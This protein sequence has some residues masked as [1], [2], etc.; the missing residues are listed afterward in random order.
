MVRSFLITLLIGNHCAWSQTPF[1]SEQTIQTIEISFSASNWDYQLDTAKLGGDNYVKAQWVKINDVTF[2]N[3]GVKYKGNSSYDSSSLKNP[4]HI[5]LDAFTDQNYKGVRDIK[6]SNAYA[7]PSMVREVLAYHIARNYMPAPQ[8]NFAKVYINNQYWGLYTNTESINKTFCNNHF[9]S[10]EG[11]FV[12]CNP[13]L[14]PSPAVKSNL[15]QLVGDSTAYYDY[16]EMKSDYGWQYLKGLCDTLT[17]H[18]AFIDNV[19]NIDRV[20]WM[21]AFNTLLVNLDS[22]NGAF[23]QNYYLY[24]DKTGRFNPL[25]WDLNMSF[26]GFPFLG[27]SNTSL[28]N[29]SIANMQ[30]LPLNIHD[31]DPYW[32]LINAIQL[33]SSYKKMYVAHLRTILNQFFNNGEYV[34]LFNTYQSLID[35]AVLNDNRKKYTYVQFKNSLTNNTSVGSYSVPGIQTL[36]SARVNYLKSTNDF[37]SSTPTIQAVT[38]SVPQLNSLINVTAHIQNA[39]VAILLYRDKITNSFERVTM[40]DDGLHDDGDAN[41]Q[42]YGTNFTLK[43]NNVQYYIYSE[44]TNAGIFSPEAAQHNFY[45]INLFSHPT[46]G[47]IFINEFLTD[48]KSDVRNEFHIH[49]DW[50]ELYNASNK[51]VSLAKCFISDDLNNKPKFHFP[52]TSTLAPKSFL[53]IWADEFISANDKIH[54]NFKLSS[55]NGNIILSDGAYSIFDWISYN[56]QSTDVS[57]ARCP[58]GY[59]DF[60]ANNLPSFGMNNCVVGIEEISDTNNSFLI[61]PNPTNNI[62]QIKNVTQANSLIQIFDGIGKL[63]FQTIYQ[64]NEKISTQTLPNGMYVLKIANAAQKLLVSH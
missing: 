2:N 23:A 22:Y 31:N 34:N 25:L 51:V 55:D 14:T 53:T 42:F 27:T 6:L 4:I 40:Y 38:H 11:V 29:L 50:I 58:D 49:Q 36:M 12:K 9:L 33:N 13:N 43:S 37:T 8:S 28:A 59:G 63:V 52:S 15:K 26:G 20:I 44:N 35:D 46:K 57:M 5:E 1:Y 7:D 17:N 64:S 10:K 41:D 61:Y 54:T 19:M 21:L 16:Y 47:D 30:N 18:P 60:E 48:N 3:V 24:R 39:N 56:T 32:P 62:F 45:E